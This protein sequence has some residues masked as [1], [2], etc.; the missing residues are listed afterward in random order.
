MMYSEKEN[1]VSSICCLNVEIR[2]HAVRLCLCYFI[3][4][5]I[6]DGGCD[7]TNKDLSELALLPLANMV[8]RSHNS[9]E[10][11]S[12]DIPNKRTHQLSENSDGSSDSSGEYFSNH[13]VSV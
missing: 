13:E 7:L 12:G 2:S 11:S 6:S 1:A 4:C 10:C 8:S 3:L 5:I 9:S